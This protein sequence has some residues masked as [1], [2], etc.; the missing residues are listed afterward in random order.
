MAEEQQKQQAQQPNEGD[1]SPAPAE[2][3]TH[4]ADMAAFLEEHDSGLVGR[5]SF[6][7]SDA[8]LGGKRP[9]TEA[10]QASGAEEEPTTE[11]GEGDDPET[12][13][14]E[15]AEA[16][17][18]ASPEGAPEAEPPDGNGES[19]T[20]PGDAEGELP[21]GAKRRLNRQKRRFRRESEA[22]DARIAQL[23]A[24]LSSNGQQQQQ[25]GTP[26]AAPPTAA[27]EDDDPE[28][29]PHPAREDY[30]SDDD[31]LADVSNWEDGKPLNRQPAKAEPPKETPPATPPPREEAPPGVDPNQQVQGMF[32]NLAE[33]IDDWEEGPEDLAS[34]FFQAQ[35][36]GTIQLSYTMLEFMADDDRGAELAKMFL[37]KPRASRRIAHKPVSQQVQAMESLLNGAAAPTTATEEKPKRA[38]SAPDIKPLGGAQN[39]VTTTVDNAETPEE[40]QRL[41]DEALEK[42]SGTFGFHV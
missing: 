41:Y 13:P 11:P 20:K 36:D 37:E 26:P 16:Q 4:D 40:F 30:D 42:K 27:G 34:N 19:G 2:E 10:Q 6:S 12:A 8:L 9:P 23:E 35:R 33:A 17:G 32:R 39:R 14:E 5:G 1:P 22:K 15:G 31:F 28:D 21:D 18:E 29:V 38:P 3:S 25:E 7:F 24:Q